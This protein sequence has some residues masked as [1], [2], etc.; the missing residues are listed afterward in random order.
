[1][2]P[3]R[4]ESE[5]L[6]VKGG[7]VKSRGEARGERHSPQALALRL[8]L[9]PLTLPARGHEHHHGTVPDAPRAQAERHAPPDL[10]LAL[11]RLVVALALASAL[12]PRHGLDRPPRLPTPARLAEPLAALEPAPALS[13]LDSRSRTHRRRRAPPR[14]A[15][16]PRPAQALRR[17]G[18]PDQGQHGRARRHHGRQHRDGPQVSRGTSAVPCSSAR[19]RTLSEAVTRGSRQQGPL[20]PARSLVHRALEQVQL[21]RR[22]CPL[23]A[24]PCA[25]RRRARGRGRGGGSAVALGAAARR[26]LAP[27]ELSRW[28]VERRTRRARAS[29]RRS[30]HSFSPRAHLEQPLTPSR[31]CPGPAGES[32]LVRRQ[33][34]VSVLENVADEAP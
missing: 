9:D 25:R 16:A 6:G 21:G 23:P 7:S 31:L 2:A 5:L 19:L 14:P 22:G 20:R 3:P 33:S 12:W 4:Q 10:P 11:A 18:S 26:A 1:V 29:A 8:P 28:H 17:H 30:Q 27:V 24:E 32:H 15:T 34:A 13:H